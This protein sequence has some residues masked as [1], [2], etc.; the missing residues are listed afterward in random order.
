[1]LL[2]CAGAAASLAGVWTLAGLSESSS[3]RVSPRVMAAAA[4]GLLAEASAYLAAPAALRA[5]LSLPLL[6]ATAG[7]VS[8]AV[9][10]AKIE[11][12]LEQKDGPRVVRRSAGIVA[13]SF[14]AMAAVG[15]ASLDL[16]QSSLAHARLGWA[17]M[18]ALVASTLAIFLQRTRYAGAGLL[19]LGHRAWLLAMIIVA[20]LVGAGLT[21]ASSPRVATPTPVAA[22]PPPVV[23]AAEPS[24]AVVVPAVVVPAAASA[25]P[26]IA[27][28]A[29]SPAAPSAIVIDAVTAHGLLEADARGGVTRRLDR[30]TACLADPK[31]QGTGTLVVKV[32][33][34]PSG[35]VTTSRPVDGDLAST[36][37]GACL[38]AVFYKMGFAAPPGSGA[39]FEITLRVGAP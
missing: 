24:P 26:V 21:R 38:V 34:D 30:L 4:A 31:N 10:A 9:G 22:L 20:L 5:E 23:A 12:A 2:S 37:L 13:G 18:F 1:M 7:V 28:S 39:G 36:P 35:S 3:L 8:L 32:R 19:A 6:F 14:F 17:L 33:I 25:P 15:A 27:S 16:G 11:R 29:P